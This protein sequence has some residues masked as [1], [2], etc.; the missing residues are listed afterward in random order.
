MI[1]QPSRDSEVDEA[2]L[3]SFIYCENREAARDGIGNRRGVL[4][5]YVCGL[6]VQGV[7]GRRLVSRRVESW[8]VTSE[9]GYFC[10]ELEER[11]KRNQRIEHERLGSVVLVKGLPGDT[12]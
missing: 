3:G 7:A 10:R 11:M 8:N 5:R 9:S 4:K 6:N 2:P 12:E 1:T